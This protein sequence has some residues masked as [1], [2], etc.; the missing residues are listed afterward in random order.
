MEETK[1]LGCFLSIISQA[2]FTASILLCVPCLVNI[3]TVIKLAHT[4]DYCPEILN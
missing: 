4:S 3:R 2:C 1:C